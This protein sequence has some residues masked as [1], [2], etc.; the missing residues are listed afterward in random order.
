MASQRPR[1]TLLAIVVAVSVLL[2]FM[3]DARAFNVDKRQTRIHRSAPGSGF[4][5][6]IAFYSHANEF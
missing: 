4:G 3:D 1:A 5:Y 2:A 6:S